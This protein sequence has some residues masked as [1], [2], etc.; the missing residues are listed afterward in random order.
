MSNLIKLLF[1]S[2]IIL[3]V[4]CPKKEPQ[5][6]AFNVQGMK[7]TIKR[8]QVSPIAFAGANIVV[9]GYVTDISFA[10]EVVEE[11]DPADP[12]MEPIEDKE[13]ED[14]EIQENNI[15]I[16]SDSGGNTINVEFEEIEG[17]AVGDTVIVRGTYNNGENM[18]VSDE[19]IKVI[20]DKDG[21][22]PYKDEIIEIDQ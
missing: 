21:I 18:I 10:D 12:E 14:K 22:R 3:L 8:V 6:P 11:T 1:F 20:V 13:I 4:S 16:L 19:L 7:T 5:E 9:L 2:T 15:L 17:I